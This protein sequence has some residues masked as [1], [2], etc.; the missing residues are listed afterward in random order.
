MGFDLTKE[1]T[2]DTGFNYLD[3]VFKK[4]T[5]EELLKTYDK[6]KRQVD[7]TSGTLGNI[8]DPIL[9]FRCLHTTFKICSRCS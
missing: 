4:K 7:P 3:N 1:S 6:R 8:L 2:F 9:R 5:Q